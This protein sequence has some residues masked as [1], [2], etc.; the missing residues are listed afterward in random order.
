MAVHLAAV[1]AFFLLGLY[2]TR[3][4]LIPVDLLWVVWFVGS[5]ALLSGRAALLTLVAGLGAT[6]FLRPNWRFASF[7]W[8]GAVLV[9]AAVLLNIS[10][11]PGSGPGVREISATQ[12]ITNLR[13]IV[14]DT[15]Q[16]NN[17]T[18]DWRLEWWGDIAGYTLGGDAFWR[19]RGFG[20]NIAEEDGF[21]TLAGDLRSPHS[22]HFTVLARMGVPGLALWLALHSAFAFSLL[23]NIR[24]AQARG[25]HHWQAILTWILVYWAAA[26]VNASF[27]VY[28]EGPQGAI[29]FW[30]VF[31][32]GIAAIRIYA[33]ERAE[34][35]QPQPLR[36]LSSPL[37]AGS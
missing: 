10:I 2:S 3:R 14:S 4:R 28:L 9:A 33:A 30:S 6:A 16:R 27:D 19:G 7:L 13:S 17:S 23:A 5:A 25:D 1:A 18:R 32:A 8:V 35:P 31:G 34:S 20:I 21:G 12:V 15:D 11:R 29:W 26:L 24:R 22:A 37:S 36:Q